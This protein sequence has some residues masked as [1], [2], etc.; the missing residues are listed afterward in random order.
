MNRGRH[1]WIPAA[2]FL[3]A[4]AVAP[5]AAASGPF[6]FHSPSG[7]F[8][9]VVETL[10]DDWTHAHKAKPGAALASRDQYA[11]YFYV[12]KSSEPVN[13]LYY[14]D[15]DPP[16]AM[17]ALIQTMQWSPEENYVVLP[18]KQKARQANHR[19]QLAAPL[20]KNKVWSLEAD[21]VHWLDDHRFVGDLNTPEVTGGIL[22]FDGAAGK[23]DLMI[24]PDPGIGY[25]IAAVT[26]NT[27][28]VR[29][30][31]NHLETGKTTWDLF[32]PACFDVNVETLKKRSTP[33]PKETPAVP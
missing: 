23:A 17:E 20:H 24:A 27:V 21:H 18:D 1:R 33:C 26:G 11:I 28:T 7:R 3:T 8:D 5:L 29:E 32:V 12:A 14:A 10:P 25:Q 9:L 2:V 19:Y 15:A 4:G 16:P 22:E 31:L 13:V 30:F 6:R